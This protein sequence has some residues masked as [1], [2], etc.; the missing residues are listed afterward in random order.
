MKHY[1]DFHPTALLIYY[2][3][4]I[5]EVMFTEDP[6]IQLI[7]LIGGI[8]SFR[9]PPSGKTV[10][11]GGI[12]AVA[13]ALTNPLFVRNG[14]TPLLFLNGNPI[15]LEALL[16][17]VSL[18]IGLSG[19]LVIFGGLN[20]AVDSDCF[21]YLFSRSTPKL[22]LVVS[23]TFRLIPLFIKRINAV[24]DAAKTQ[25]LLS[26]EGLTDRI[27]HSLTV[28]RTVFMWS[29]ENAADTAASMTARGYGSSKRTSFSLYKFER[30]D[31]LL[32]A[33]SV[34]AAIPIFIGESVGALSF[35]F[36]PTVSLP[37]MTELSLISRGCFVLLVMIPFTVR[38]WEKITWNYYISRI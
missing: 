19:M 21:V 6:I 5:T 17:G 9:K 25:G 24:S 37:Q 11:L 1:T 23:M 16:A 20:S 32:I 31:A 30:R 26:S 12:I 15:T 28:F 18:A 14:A 33:I 4:V 35:S 38:V 7:A 3:L 2:I 34:I 13:I 10:L 8:L 22:A 29:L 36:Y 27:K